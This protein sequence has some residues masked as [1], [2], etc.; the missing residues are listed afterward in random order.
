MFI[1]ISLNSQE[2]SQSF[3][4]NKVD[5]CNFIKKETLGQLFSFG[6]CEIFKNTCLYRTA[7]GVAFVAI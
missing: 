1:E 7:P 3:F 6:F 5:T 4:F 2:N